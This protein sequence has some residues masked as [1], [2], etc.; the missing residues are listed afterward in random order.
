MARE[1]TIQFLR[2]TSTTSV[3]TLAAG[4]PY[5][6]TATGDLIIGDNVTAQQIVSLVN[7]NKIIPNI[8]T[9][10]DIF[11]I[12]IFDANTLNLSFDTQNYTAAVIALP[13]SVKYSGSVIIPKRVYKDKKIYEVTSIGGSAFRACRDLTSITIPDSVTSIGSQAFSSCS[14]L[15]SITIGNG[16]TSIGDSAFV[17]CTGLTSITIP[18]SVTSIGSQAFRSCSGLTS[19]TIGNGV[20]SIGERAFQNCTSLTSITIP[21]SVTSIGSYA[22]ADCTGLTS[23]TILRND[24]STISGSPW[25]ATSAT[26]TYIRPIALDSTDWTNLKTNHYLTKSGSLTHLS[27][28]DDF[29]DYKIKIDSTYHPVKMVKNSNNNYV[30]MLFVEESSNV[31]EITIYYNGSST[32]FRCAEVM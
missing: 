7:S 11:N 26:V 21:D 15:T 13:D 28:N 3:E 23:I 14:G 5:F 30:G 16:V 32:I 12:S 9:I 24:D 18:D 10:L 2:G 4:E 31:Y 17:S 25:R 20:T 19:I 6:N 8:N 22:F 29:I 1:S 27:S